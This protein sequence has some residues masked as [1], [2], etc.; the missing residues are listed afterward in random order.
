MGDSIPISQ[1]LNLAAGGDAQAEERVFSTVYSELR[2]LAAAQRARLPVGDT[3]DTTAV[4]HEAYLRLVEQQ[5]VS[6]NGRHHFFCAAAR[7]MRNLLIDEARRKGTA[8]R[9][10]GLRSVPLDDVVRVDEASPEDL[11]ALDQALSKLE[12][13]DA[14]DYQVVMLRYFAGLTV[15]ETADVLGASRRSVERRWQFCRSWLARE[16]GHP[17]D[18]G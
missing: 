5:Q 18:V 3:L 12:E 6:W 14:D 10:A 8:K 15:G 17:G 7:S 1:L 16:L 9:G 4:V 11:L 2:R 13:E